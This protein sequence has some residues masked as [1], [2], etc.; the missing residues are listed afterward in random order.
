M[1]SKRIF[2]AIALVAACTA[3]QAAVA[4]AATIAPST[5]AD[6]LGEDAAACS[7]REA[8]QAANSDAAVAGCPAGSGPDTIALAPDT[9]QLSRPGGDEDGNATG[10]LDISGD[11]T[12]TNRSVLP[13]T[14]D[15]SAGRDRVLHLLS[16]SVT[17]ERVTIQGGDSNDS[18][19]GIFTATPTSLTLHDSTVTGNRSNYHG[20]GIASQGTVLIRNVTITGNR[21]AASGGG[22]ARAA[23]GQIGA[24]NN[25]T[26]TGNLADSDSGGAAGDG[27]GVAVVGSGDALTLKNSIVAANGDASTSG[28]VAP[29]CGGGPTSLGHNLV[30]SIASCGYTAG[31]GDSIGTD[32]LLASL[33]DNGGPT[34][35]QALLVASPAI[36]N[37]GVD[38]AP[39][40]QRGAARESCDIGAYERVRCGGRLVNRVG[41]AGRDVLVG[42]PGP[43]GFLL[44]AGND[45]ARGLAGSDGICGGA[46]KD[47]LKGGPGKDRLL[48]E[49]G[50]DRL[51]GGGGADLLKG[52]GGRD[53]CWGGPGKDSERSCR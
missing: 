42:G 34:P 39:A 44:G 27:G 50:K 28:T 2:L 1:R 41:T 49:R 10:D 25:A 15:G 9:Y 13:A 26:I 8:V 6:Q 20:G 29:E 18:G 23:N 4:S 7:L 22:Y 47:R 16:G 12:I 53:R 37:G 45:L 36:D 14:V 46:G 48:G 43:D 5:T 38:C 17:V 40:D 3:W 32:P 21:A 11:L 52:G 35:T 31:G 33:A 19:G 51:I 30:A 24:I